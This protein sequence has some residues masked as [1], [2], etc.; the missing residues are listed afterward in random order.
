MTSWRDSASATAQQD[1]DGLLNVTLPFAQQQLDK[2]GEFFPFGAVVNADG[3]NGLVAPDP[4]ATGERPASSQV[5]S[6]LVQQT[7]EMRSELRAVALCSDVRL[8]DRD[9]IRVELEHS[10]GAS[11]AVL[12]PYKKKRLGNR[13]E[14]GDLQAGTATPSIWAD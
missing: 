5:L 3:T 14:Y 1:L 12:M 4:A 9:A 2:H 10:E 8:A 13:I 11:M 6:L 7:R